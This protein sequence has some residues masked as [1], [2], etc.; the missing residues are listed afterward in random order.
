VILV[1]NTVIGSPPW[2]NFI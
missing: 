1:K 2:K